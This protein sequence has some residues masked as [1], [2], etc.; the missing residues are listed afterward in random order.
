MY[1][2]RHLKAISLLL[3]VAVI[4][5]SIHT[6]ADK[7]EP[8]HCSSSSEEA[9]CQTDMSQAKPGYVAVVTGA[10]GAIGRHIVAELLAS[11]KWQKITTIGRRPLQLPEELQ[12][13]AA[14]GRLVQQ[15]VDMDNLEAHQDAF[16]TADVHFCALGTTRKDAGSAEAFR[17]VD[18]DYVL[19]LAQM[20]KQ[21]NTSI[22]S[23]V[24]SSGASQSRYASSMLMLF[25]LVLITV[26]ALGTAPSC[27]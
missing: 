4:T 14:D 23:L 22:F 1:A 27:T 3:A 11:S 17:K 18:Y 12:K 16:A 26:L 6:S 7:A 2:A 10:T 20:S 19:K 8:N 25:R 9:S 24:S 21:A 5:K 15:T 13:K